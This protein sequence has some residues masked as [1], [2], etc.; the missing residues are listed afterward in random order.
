M[1]RNKTNQE[2]KLIIKVIQR[3]SNF[4]NVFLPW[5]GKDA[6]IIYIYIYIYIYIDSYLC[7]SWGLLTNIVDGGLTVNLESIEKFRI[8]VTVLWNTTILITREPKNH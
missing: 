6:Q 1:V 5:L 3:Y 4:K 2:L 7:Q 8:H